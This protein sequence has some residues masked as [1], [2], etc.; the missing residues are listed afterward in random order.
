MKRYPPKQSRKYAK[1][2]SYYKKYIA[3]RQPNQSKA[4]GT[5]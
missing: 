2:K 3:T 1:R 4:R 5:K